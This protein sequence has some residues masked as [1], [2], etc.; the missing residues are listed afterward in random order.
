MGQQCLI[1]YYVVTPTDCLAVK[2]SEISSTYNALEYQKFVGF[3]HRSCLEKAEK[4]RHKAEL[5][6]TR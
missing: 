5:E 4:D 3:I 1:C 6:P 2:S